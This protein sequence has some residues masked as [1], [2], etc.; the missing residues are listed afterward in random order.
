M[1]IKNFV[2]CLFRIQIDSTQSPSIEN[3]A[4]YLQSFY[5]IEMYSANIEIEIRKFTCFIH[6]INAFKRINCIN[7]CK[8][9]IDKRNKSFIQ[10][11]RRMKIGIVKKNIEKSIDCK[12]NK[13]KTFDR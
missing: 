3:K 13:Y 8:P 2:N 6:F 9:S 12:T 4:L 1:G 7:L 11:L 5:R 10:K